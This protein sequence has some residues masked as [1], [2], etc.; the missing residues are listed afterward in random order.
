MRA[1]AVAVEDDRRKR[2]GA[3]QLAG[4]RDTLI[5]LLSAGSL[6]AVAE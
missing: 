1:T 5:T 3:E 4:F 6:G 2:L